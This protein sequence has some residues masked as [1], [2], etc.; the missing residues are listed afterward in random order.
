MKTNTFTHAF[1]ALCSV[2]TI[3]ILITSLGCSDSSPSSTNV[4]QA[5]QGELIQGDPIETSQEIQLSTPAIEGV[6]DTKPAAVAANHA[7]IRTTEIPVDNISVVESNEVTQGAGQVIVSASEPEVLLEIVKEGADLVSKDGD[8]L[9]ISF[10]KLASFEYTMPEDLTEPVADEEGQVYKEQIPASIK[11]LNDKPI[12]LKG[13]MLPLKVEK[14]SVTEMLIMRDQSMCCYGTVPKI[15]EWVSVRMEEEGVK[16][17][18]D[19]PVTIYGTLKV[20]EVLENGYLV[21]IYEMD[22]QS[23]SVEKIDQ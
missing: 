1:R 16:P 22:G 12:S 3:L 6:P 7:G 20:G 19:E 15:N 17:V 13:F 11:A 21:G 14:G 18:M 9:S 8:Y 4:S 5:P 23:M 2:V 10:D